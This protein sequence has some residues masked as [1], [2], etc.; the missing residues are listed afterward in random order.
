MN[1]VDLNLE[2]VQRQANIE[3]SIIWHQVDALTYQTKGALPKGWGV[4]LLMYHNLFVSQ[5]HSVRIR[6]GRL[7]LSL[8]VAVK[9]IVACLH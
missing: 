5:N 4:G 1:G 2:E 8:A 7:L 6:F 3:A 9:S